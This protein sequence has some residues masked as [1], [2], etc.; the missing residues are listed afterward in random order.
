MKKIAVIPNNPNQNDARLKLEQFKKYEGWGGGLGC[1]Q[2]EGQ[3]AL[4]YISG[5]IQQYKYLV[6][7][8]NID[9]KNK[10]FDLILISKFNDELSKKFNRKKLEELGLPKNGII[11]Y[12]LDKYPKILKY[13]SDELQKSN[14]IKEP[15]Y[16]NKDI[17]NDNNIYQYNNKNSEKENRE[18]GIKPLNRI[19]YG[20][21]GTGKTYNIINR[22]LAIIENKSLREL[23][24]EDREEL[25]RRFDEYKEKGQIEFVTFHQSYGYEEFVE[26]IKAESDENG[27]LSYSVKDGIFKELSD[28]A[29]EY[30]KNYILIID[31]INRGNI[32][33]IFGELITLIESS[34]RIGADEE[35]KVRLPYSNEE[36]GV[37]KNLYIL[38][39]MNTADRSIAL[40]DTALRRRFEF[41]EMMPKPELLEGIEVDGIDIKNMLEIINKRI[42]YLYDRDHMI[43]HSYFMSLENNPTI[44]ELTN[45]FKNKIIPLLQEYF[46]D[47]FE[48]IMMVLGE[49][50]IDKKEIKPDIFDY[51]IDDYLDDEEKFIYE[52]KEKF[53]FSKFKK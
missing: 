7:I 26:G 4:L 45:I 21:P 52:I 42:E 32:S 51:Q 25:K 34:K 6:K 49:G 16:K 29:K 5:N 24:N 2:K 40:L 37:P 43:G 27:N 33:K 44:E 9:K 28:K 36:F 19:L 31:E 10:K 41:I 30:L 47:D 23:E 38:G 8:V 22:A 50:F 48:K 12:C 3:L 53:D 13:V 14:I 15:W 46:Y 11:R 39:T 35:I 1:I 20:P 18:K 17:L